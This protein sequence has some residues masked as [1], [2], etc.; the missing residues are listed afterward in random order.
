MHEVPRGRECEG[1]CVRVACCRPRWAAEDSIYSPLSGIC[2]TR[3]FK[4]MRWLL[5]SCPVVSDS[6]IS[7]TAALQA[8]LSVISSWTAVCQTSLSTVSQSFLMFIFIASVMPSS[9]LIPR[10][11]FLPLPSVF[12][13]TR[14]FSNESSFC[15]R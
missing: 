6:V 1:P 2:V 14:D 5:F 10:R 11:P 13:S 7:W 3:V 4:G 15:I 12:P 8:S 9:H